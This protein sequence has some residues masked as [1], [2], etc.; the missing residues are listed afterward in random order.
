MFSDS[1]KIEQIVH[2]MSEIESKY[3]SN[4]KH[5]INV[6]TTDE[7]YTELDKNELVKIVN[8][9][10]K[11]I[12]T[13][14]Y[15]L[16]ENDYTISVIFQFLNENVGPNGNYNLMLDNKSDNEEIERMLWEKLELKKYKFSIG[17]PAE[18]QMIVSPL[19]TERNFDKKTNKCFVL[20]PFT[21]AWSDRVWGKI[22]EILVNEDLVCERADNLF[23][24]DILE[25]IWKAINE[26]EYIIADITTR[27]PNVFYEI[28]IAHTLGKKVILLTQK[29]TDIP[30]DFKRYR[31]IIYEDNVDGFKILEIEIPKYLE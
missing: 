28:G 13:V 30:F 12:N 6:T 23:G 21:E 9:Q 26:S 22:K 18:K 11:Q 14:Q 1:L 20:M 27:N 8:E 29:V 24:H 4:P 3:Y 17:Q 5:N 10:N 31:H 25:D 16:T 15:I 7:N 19:F 2:V